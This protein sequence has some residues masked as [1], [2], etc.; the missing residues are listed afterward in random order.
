MRKAMKLL[1]VL[2]VCLASLLGWAKMACGKP[3]SI[4]AI[5]I[6]L[7]PDAALDQYAKA[8]NAR[9]LQESP[10]GF[11]FDA[12]H[13]PHVTF[14]QRYVLTEH[15][16]ALFAAVDRVLAR[17]QGVD[18]KLRV[19]RYGYTHWKHKGIGGLSIEPTPALRALQQQLIEAVAP[20]TVATGTA[21]AFFTTPDESDIN[22]TTVDYVETFIP[23]HTGDNYHPH[24][25]LGIASLDYLKQ[26][27]A[28]PFEAFTVSP[29]GVSVYQ[30]GNFGTARK[31][32]KTW[33]L[34]S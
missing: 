11:A 34:P 2:G 31:R 3:Q 19:S 25:T 24:I 30:L 10:E 17:Q 14:L 29:A 8:A 26:I 12:T 7:D 28:E 33:P 4:T 6:A 18:L 23:Q 20:F 16:D 5:D 1:A 27:A 13:Q 32:L 15:L 21:A 22:P 9:L